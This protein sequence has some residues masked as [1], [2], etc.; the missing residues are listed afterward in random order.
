MEGALEAI[1][2]SHSCAHFLWKRKCVHGGGAGGHMMET[3][4][5]ERE[6][7]RSGWESLSPTLH[8]VFMGSLWKALY[9]FTPLLPFLSL[10]LPQRNPLNTQ[11][12]HTSPLLTILTGRVNAR[13]L[14]TSQASSTSLVFHTQ[15]SSHQSPETH[16]LPIRSFLTWQPCSPFRF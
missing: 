1:W 3:S 7:Q 2:R 13:A 14:T 12:D 5:S 4:H 11:S 6:A 8:H 16:S 10:S 15:L 9:A